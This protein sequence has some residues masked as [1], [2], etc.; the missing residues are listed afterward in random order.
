MQKKHVECNWYVHTLTIA[1][2]RE[3]FAATL[4]EA[5][6]GGV[7]TTR[8]GRPLAYIVGADTFHRLI[9]SDPAALLESSEVAPASIDVAQLAEEEPLIAHD[10]L[11]VSETL[12]LLREDRV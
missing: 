6:A 7:E 11:S 2:A 3:R 8:H 12:E 4:A 1:Q 9:S 5:Q 10:E